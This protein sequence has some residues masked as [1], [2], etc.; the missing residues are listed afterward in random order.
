[1]FFEACYG[2]SVE[3]GSRRSMTGLTRPVRG[4][5]VRHVGTWRKSI[6]GGSEKWWDLVNVNGHGWWGPGCQGKPGY[7]TCTGI[8][9]MLVFF[10]CHL[11]GNFS[12]THW[13]FTILFYHMPIPVSNLLFSY[14]TIFYAF[15]SKLQTSVHI[16]LNTSACILLTRF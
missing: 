5:P 11:F 14:Q 15:Q 2:S 1:M 4:H 8:S 16:F 13:G 9:D 3:R 10:P 7:L 12:N 6:G